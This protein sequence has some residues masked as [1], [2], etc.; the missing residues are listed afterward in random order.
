MRAIIHL[1]DRVLLALM[2]AELALLGLLILTLAVSLR[3]IHGT[4]ARKHD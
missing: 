2:L 3:I 1:L 4:A